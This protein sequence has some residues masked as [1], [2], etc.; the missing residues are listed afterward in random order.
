MDDT[1]D[2][3]SQYPVLLHLLRLLVLLALQQ[4]LYDIVKRFLDDNIAWLLNH[5][6]VLEEAIPE[7]VVNDV[8]VVLVI[9]S[10]VGVIARRRGCLDHFRMIRLILL[11]ITGPSTIII[12]IGSQS[13][14]GP[15]PVLDLVASEGAYHLDPCQL[16]NTLVRNLAEQEAQKGN[17]C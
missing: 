15:G 16:L 12:K 5:I 7:E 2:L 4:E 6:K 1:Y 9:S 14:N 8:E 13:Q 11:I 17:Q 3:A 10:I